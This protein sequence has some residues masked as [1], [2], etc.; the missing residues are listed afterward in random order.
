MWLVH[1]WALRAAPAGLSKDTVAIGVYLREYHAAWPWSEARWRWVD[2]A[3]REVTSLR[4]FSDATALAASLRTAARV[5]AVADPHITRWLAPSV[6]LDPEP[7][8]F[9]VVERRCHSFSQWWT[10]A[11]RGYEQAGELL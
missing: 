7:A 5:R 3:M 10:R 2:T 1:P 6:Q 9:P 11:T 4:C 8:L